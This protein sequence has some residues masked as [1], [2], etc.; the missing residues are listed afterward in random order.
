M[1][2]KVVSIFK[3]IPREM[4]QCPNCKSFHVNLIMEGIW[5]PERQE[6]HDPALFNHADLFGEVPGW[7]C[8]DCGLRF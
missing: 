3:Y 8:H 2:G 6:E 7:F 4:G 1:S 5:E